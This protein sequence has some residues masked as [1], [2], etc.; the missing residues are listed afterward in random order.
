MEIVQNELNEAVEYIYEES[1]C[2][3]NIEGK[4]I[5]EDHM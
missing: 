5:Y 2:V 1:N 3:K 4:N